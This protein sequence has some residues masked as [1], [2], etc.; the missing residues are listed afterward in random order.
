[1]SKIWCFLLTVCLC[2]PFVKVQAAQDVK[3]VAIIDVVDREGSVAYGMKLVLRSSLSE[4]VTN[5]A[6]YEGYDRVDISSIMDEQH[7]QQTGLVN[8]A[9]IRKIGEMT[10][11]SYILVAEMA[12]IDDFKLIIT[13]K[14]LDV[15]TAKLENT[16]HV[17]TGSATNQ[18]REA[19]QQLAQALLG[20]SDN[21]GQIDR[22]PEKGKVVLYC[23]GTKL[24]PPRHLPIIVSIDGRKL[25]EGSVG[26]GFYFELSN[27]Q[28]GKH[29]LKFQVKNTIAMG[30]G[31]KS[32]TI[33]IS[34]EYARFYEFGMKKTMLRATEFFSVILKDSK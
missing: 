18:L 23:E 6:G 33:V 13:A 2:A 1:M 16:A 12:K 9:E 4:A 30:L 15:E 31:D 25:G 22:N 5:T 17:Q 21:R 14:I 10:G 28:D 32:S 7:F 24:V 26:E 19:C 3:K 27:I 34:P 29:K 11:A 8:D 20:F